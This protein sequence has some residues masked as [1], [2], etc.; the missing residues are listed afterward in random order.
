MYFKYPN[1]IVKFLF[2]YTLLVGKP[3]FETQTLKDTY[4]RIKRNEYHIP[5]RIGPLARS[6]IQRLLQGDPTRRPNV[7]V[8]LADDF[9][10]MGELNINL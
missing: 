1:E 8:I 9:M 7:D 2:R 5:S 3:P 10:T 4:M 6:L